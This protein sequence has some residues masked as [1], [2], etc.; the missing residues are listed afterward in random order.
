[1]GASKQIFPH[2]V[3]EYSV[4]KHFN[5]YNPNTRKLYLTL[6]VVLFLGFLMMFFIR[7]D[8]SVKS[9]GMIRPVIER[10]ELK[11]PVEG[12][13]DSIYVA[14]N[15]HV[16]AGQSLIKI[17]SKGVEDRAGALGVQKEEL[18]AQVEDLQ[19]LLAGKTKELRSQ[20]YSQQYQL[21]LQRLR[22]A[23]IR[24]GLVAKNYNRFA[25]LYKTRAISAAEYDKYNYE[26]MDAGND[27]ALIKDQQLSQ[28]QADLTR[29]TMQLGDMG[30]RLSSYEEEKDLHTIKAPVSGTVQRMTGIVAGSYVTPNDILG[31][32]SPDSGLIAETYVLP[33]DIGLLNKGTKV[34]MQVDAFNYNVWGMLTGTVESV[35]SDI[36]TDLGQPYFKVRCKIDDPVLKLRNGYKGFVKKGMTVQAR[37]VVT[38]RTLFQLLYDETDDWLNPNVINHEKTAQR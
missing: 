28:W 26:R 7:V 35:S 32:I 16:R 9:T 17:H 33:R 2:E 22:D 23:Q 25:R 3:V 11:V 15:E 30:V 14:E 21:Y 10:T 20:L 24:Y 18:I 38:K 37:F 31:E 1:M 4:E 13:I 12:T 5:E 6:L 34:R 27:V 8:V 19:N 29:L 36:Y